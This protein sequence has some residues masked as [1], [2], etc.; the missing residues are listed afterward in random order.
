MTVSGI[1]VLFLQDNGI[2]ESLALT[3]LSAVL[4]QQGHAVNLLIE[5]DESRRFEQAVKS[6]RPD[7]V[8]VPCNVYAQGYV[9]DLVARVRRWLPQTRVLVGGT[10]PTF[11]PDFINEDVID[12]ELV[13]EAD[14]AVPQLA[15]CLA[16]GK[17]P[18]GIPGIWVKDAAGNVAKTG[19][20]PRVENLDSMPLPDRGLYYRYPYQARFPWKKFTTGRG[21]ANDCAF[22]YNHFVREVYGGS[23]FV[24]R[25][26]PSRVL[27]EVADVARQASLD[28]VHFADDL[29]VTDLDWLS[30]LSRL[31]PASFKLPF[32]CNSSAERLTSQAT[33]LLSKAGCRV[34]AMGVETADEAFRIRLMNKPAT[35]RVLFEAAENVHRHGMKLVVFFM[36]GLPGERPEQA[37]A[38][39]RLARTLRADATRLM[40]AVPLPGTRMTRQAAEQ[41][42]IDAHVA[43][44]FDAAVDFIRDPFGPY[45]RLDEPGAIETLGNTAPWASLVPSPAIMAAIARRIPRRLTRPLRLW[46][47]FQEKRIF[48]FSLVDGLRH[49]LHVGNP[50]RRTTNYVTLI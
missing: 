33:A 23:H 24:R 28:W 15:D 22:C 6:A 44:D 2:N 3:E 18:T 8:I 16:R 39:L 29:F 34:V 4:K 30:E 27:E 36:L 45:Y 10:H 26:S 41:G 19:P 40:M 43:A 7:L 17:E 48:G 13:G 9:L 38:T 11:S 21:C 50:M 49:Y 47:S 5:R 32:S 25:K 1:S 42:Y 20:G 31:Y 35:D 12:L 14:V 46:M 37:A